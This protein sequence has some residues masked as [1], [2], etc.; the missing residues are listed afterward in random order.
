MKE[1]KQRKT[2]K[3][4]IYNKI[5]TRKVMIE[6]ERTKVRINSTN[7]VQTKLYTSETET[8]TWF[9][10][11]VNYIFIEKKTYKENIFSTSYYEIQIS[12]W[13]IENKKMHSNQQTH[14]THFTFTPFLSIFIQHLYSLLNYIQIK[15]YNTTLKNISFLLVFTPKT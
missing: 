9:Q 5:Y 6:N 13:Q 11:K 4:L 3:N 15:M 14:H 8:W 2:L 10:I 1:N 7:I 12:S